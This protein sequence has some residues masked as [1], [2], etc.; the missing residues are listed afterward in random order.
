MTISPSLAAAVFAILIY[1]IYRVFQ[2]GKRP[3]GMPPGPPTVPIFGNNNE[4]CLQ[5]LGEHMMQ[6]ADEYFFQ[7]PD[8]HHHLKYDQLAR[9]Y[10]HLVTFMRGPQ[11]QVIVSSARAARDIFDKMGTIT[12]SRPPSYLMN[13]IAADGY[14]MAFAANHNEYWRLAR[15][16]FHSILNV[17]ATKQYTPLQELEST[18]FLMDLMADT[19]DFRPHIFRYSNSIGNLLTRGHRAAAPDDPDINE[20]RDN[21]DEYAALQLKGSLPDYFPPLRKLPQWIFPSIRRARE[22]CVNDA[23]VALK[24]YVPCKDGNDSLPSFNRSLAEK[25]KKE[26]FK[27]I[28]GARMG[29]DLVMVTTRHLKSLI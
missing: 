21:L 11:P 26:G 8:F 13:D 1:T 17:G 28:M 24:H 20:V 15:R 25:Q 14:S 22:H 2:I 16:L 27:D 12:A 6:N 7:L 4:V 23:K 5:V 3:A 19:S 18:K 9:E 29:L 10:G